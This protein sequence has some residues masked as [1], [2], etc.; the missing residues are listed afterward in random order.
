MQKRLGFA[1]LAAVAIAAG[2]AGQQESAQEESDRP[3][4]SFVIVPSQLS[5]QE[6]EDSLF[7][8]A[9]A[10]RTMFVNRHGGTY[11]GGWDDAGANRSSIIS[12]TR[13]VSAWSYGDAAWQQFYTCIRDE[14]ARWNV[15]V[16]DQNPGNVPHIEA[17]I[18]GTPGQIGM[19]N[20]VGGVAPMNNDCSIVEDAVV[21]V[22]SG[23]LGNNPVVACEIAAQEIGHAIG[24][25]HEYLCSD[26][27]TYLS[28]CGRKTFQDQTVSCGEYS[29]RACMCSAKQNSVQ[30]MNARLGPAGGA[31][32]TPTPGGTPTPSPTA[33]PPA[34][35][36]E[37]PVAIAISPSHEAQLWGNQTVS[38]SASITD[39]IGVTSAVLW[40][41]RDG[42]W[43][44]FDCDAPPSGI[45]CSEE[46]GTYTWTVGVG[47][48]RRWWLVRAK[49]A[50]GNQTD[51]EMRSIDYY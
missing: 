40:W 8:A 34:T 23:V 2:C 19:G 18:G 9:P 30:F 41:W 50:A 38:V 10:Q 3:R 35:D 47:T 39:D 28:G 32:P 31:T 42:N 24:M 16:T 29:P 33:T 12:G 5:P 17:V 20:G 51:S 4:G 11:Q 49:D 46:A 14:F 44:A 48:G 27:M 6:S 21:Y 45:G 13:T 1:A 36:A 26:P 15:T 7:E 43:R 25:D 22:F 37:P